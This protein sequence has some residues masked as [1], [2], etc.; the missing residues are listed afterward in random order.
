MQVSYDN[1]SDAMEAGRNGQVWGVIHFGRNFTEEFEI[2]QTEGDSATVENII[3]SRISVNVD[4]SSELRNIVTFIS[5]N[6]VYWWIYLDHQVDV[7]I[8]KWLLEAFREFRRNFMITCQYEPEAGYMP[9]VVMAKLQ[10][11]N[12]PSSVIH[13]FFFGK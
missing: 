6:I 12:F 11:S 7:F 1:V 8:E 5:I 2:R 10:D 13:L 4:S 3:R 9:V